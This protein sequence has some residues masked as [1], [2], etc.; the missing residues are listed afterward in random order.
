[1]FLSVLFLGY[2]NHCRK[3]APQVTKATRQKGLGKRCEIIPVNARL[4]RSPGD[5]IFG[6]RMEAAAR[7]KPTRVNRRCQV[8]P[9]RYI[10]LLQLVVHLVILLVDF[11]YLIDCS[12]TSLNPIIL[13]PLIIE[14]F[15]GYRW[16][17][18]DIRRR[19]S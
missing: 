1:V 8:C 13:Q 12:A 17:S 3:H 2:S 18:F 16:H 14:P 4:P 19:A 10:G 15:Y 6:S 7:V 9:I 11:N 5:C